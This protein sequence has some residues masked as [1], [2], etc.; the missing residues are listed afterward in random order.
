MNTKYGEVRTVTLNAAGE[1]VGNMIR[2]SLNPSRD[3]SVLYKA[4]EF[5]DAARRSVGKRMCI[6]TLQ[7]RWKY[8]LLRILGIPAR[9]FTWVIK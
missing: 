6:T 2:T 5:D 4:L 8:R 3:A 1:V 7:P 9:D